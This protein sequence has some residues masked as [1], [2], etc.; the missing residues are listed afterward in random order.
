MNAGMPANGPWFMWK[1]GTSS[2]RRDA[3]A[4]GH[5]GRYAIG[6]WAGRF[7]GTGRAAYVGAQAAEPLL[8]SLFSHPHL[9]ANSTPPEPDVLTVRHPLDLPKEKQDCLRITKPGQ[10]E[11]FLCRVP[12]KVSVHISANRSQ[13]IQWF[14]N[15]HLLGDNV[16]R[17]T[18]SVGQYDLRCLDTQKRDSSR[19]QFAVYP[20]AT[21]QCL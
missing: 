14:L 18:L 10:G 16:D 4:V 3:W 9:S 20:L 8:L 6:V 21:G 17:L 13:G 11:E 7:K 5:N 15:G 12:G 1:T 19:V 2:G